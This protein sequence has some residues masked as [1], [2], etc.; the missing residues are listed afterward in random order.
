MRRRTSLLFLV[1]AS[2]VAALVLF[3]CAG[4]E[5]VH[6]LTSYCVPDFEAKG[7]KT[8]GL[9]PIGDQTNSDVGVPTV[10]PLLEKRAAQEADYLFLSEE[11]ILG[12]SQK[13]GLRDTY[14]SLVSGWKKE[15]TISA[16]DAVSV[17]QASG[18]EALLFAEI[19]K[20]N[21]E[22]VTQNVEGTSR[23]QVGI[24]TVLVGCETG[25]I[26][27][28]ASDEQIMESALYSPESGIGTHVDAGGMVRS[29][30]VGGVP[31]PPPIEEVARR[32][33]EALF[34]VFP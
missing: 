19:F 31:D 28:E 27:W 4:K 26:L 8:I 11:E 2:A 12:R 34:R 29:S 33:L 5:A 3:G 18:V 24:R 15:S 30:S 9:M 13:K 6:P 14:M 10:L 32:V 20:W 1:A 25:E 23:S 16:E 17:G 21:K 7:V 22:W